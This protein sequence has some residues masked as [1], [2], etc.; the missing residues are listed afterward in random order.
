MVWHG[1]HPLHIYYHFVI[2]F[3]PSYLYRFNLYLLY[4]KFAGGGTSCV[5]RFFCL[6]RSNKKKC[7]TRETIRGIRLSQF[8]EIPP[9]FH[10]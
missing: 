9:L 2:V 6:H 1:I 7:Y 8:A 3:F 5:A 10:N 4:R